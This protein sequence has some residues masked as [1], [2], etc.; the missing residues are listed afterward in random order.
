MSRIW[1]NG[2]KTIK[3]LSYD[4]RLL[5]ENGSALMAGLN[6]GIQ[7][8]WR[9]V[10]DNISNMAGTIQDVINDDYSDIG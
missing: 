9:N 5:I 10:M 3:G 4:R 1:L 8:G 2:L 6:Q 7:T